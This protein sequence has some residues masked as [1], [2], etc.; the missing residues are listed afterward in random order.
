[1][2]VT[3]GNG[4]DKPRWASDVQGSNQ[5]AIWKQGAT[6]FVDAIVYP[7]QVGLRRRNTL[8]AGTALQ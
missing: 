4:F 5:G 2:K 3:A 1:V 6:S 7:L 8:A